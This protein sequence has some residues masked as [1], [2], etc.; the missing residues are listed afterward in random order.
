[1]DID[2]TFLNEVMKSIDR[3]RLHLDMQPK[4]VPPVARS[5][6]PLKDHVLGIGNWVRIDQTAESWDGKRLHGEVGQI[7]AFREDSS[8]TDFGPLREIR[9]TMLSLYLPPTNDRRT[10]MALVSPFEVTLCG[11]R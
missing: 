9:H 8:L 11:T 3:I 7:I 1:M 10:E 6:M 5:N 4:S 2:V